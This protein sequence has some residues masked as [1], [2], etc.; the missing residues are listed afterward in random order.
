[1]K[2]QGRKNQPRPSR[3]QKPKNPKGGSKTGTQGA[4]K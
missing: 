3:P 2:G 4:P 1:M